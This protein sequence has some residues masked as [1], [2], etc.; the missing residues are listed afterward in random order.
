MGGGCFALVIVG[1]KDEQ[2]QSH[3][4]DFGVYGGAVH[5][6]GQTGANI[7]V[8]GDVCRG[9]ANLGLSLRI[10]LLFGEVARVLDVLS[11]VA[12]YHHFHE[13]RGDEFVFCGDS[14][15]GAARLCR[16][17]MGFVWDCAVQRVVFGRNRVYHLE[18]RAEAGWGGT[19]GH[20]SELGTGVRSYFRISHFGREDGVIAICWVGGGDSGDCA[21][22]AEVIWGSWQMNYFFKMEHQH[23]Y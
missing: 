7:F 3:R 9:F 10:W 22:A 15:V 8:I 5:T 11:A 19:N 6:F 20:I 13:C 18:L 14:V 17:W 4:C 2:E 1:R 23:I 21:D 16:D 12:A